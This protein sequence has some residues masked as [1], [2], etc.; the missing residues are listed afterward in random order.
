MDVGVEVDQ[1]SVDITE[2]LFNHNIFRSGVD[3]AFSLRD[4]L[5]SMSLFDK[6]TCPGTAISQ[7]FSTP[8]AKTMLKELVRFPYVVREFGFWIDDQVFSLDNILLTGQGN[9]K[10]KKVL[11][12]TWDRRDSRA[13]DS[14]FKALSDFIRAE[15]YKNTPDIPW[16][17]EYLLDMLK[18]QSTSKIKKPLVYHNYAFMDDSQKINFLVMPYYTSRDGTRTVRDLTKVASDVFGNASSWTHHMTTSLSGSPLNLVYQ[19]GV[20]RKSFQGKNETFFIFLRHFIEHAMDHLVGNRWK[21]TRNDTPKMVECVFSNY[22]P[23]LLE[24]LLKNG[25]LSR[26]CLRESVPWDIPTLS[27]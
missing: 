23:K 1:D 13:V 19:E 5:R 9:I 7:T 10:F 25:F 14:D 6:F 12:K 3:I 11:G 24:S 18:S 27:W 21:Y 17:V 20:R 15:I 22:F 8:K 16:D 4:S 2:R 26:A